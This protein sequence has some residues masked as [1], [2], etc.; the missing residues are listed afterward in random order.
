M[1]WPRADDGR[2]RRA[3]P[4]RDVLRGVIGGVNAGNIITH[5]SQPRNRALAALFAALRIA[6]REGIGVDRMVRDMIAIG[7]RPPSI[8]EIPGP[9]VRTALFGESLDEAW[10]RFVGRI[11]PDEARGSLTVLL[12]LRE[13]VASSW[14]D[15]ATAAPLLQL[16]A[17]ETAEAIHVF[18]QLTVDGAPL[19]APVTGVP[20][21]QEPAWHLALTAA[22]A[23]TSDDATVG[24]PRPRPDRATVALSWAT[25]RGRVSSTE[26]ASILGVSQ[27]ATNRLLQS[28]RDDGLLVPS[29]A[30]QT[31]R[32]FFY[33][34]VGDRTASGR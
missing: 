6:E 15:V 14:F 13:V 8:E 11:E 20:A 19:V 25:A 33:R 4:D 9:H 34:P 17:A 18:A 10:I 2:A 30:A 24:R 12:L 31:G 7:Y 21:A 5:P 16:N 29:R 23:L 27:P 26:L 22:S 3:E 32:G 1:G 28:L